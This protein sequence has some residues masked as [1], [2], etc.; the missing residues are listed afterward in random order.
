MGTIQEPKYYRLEKCDMC[1]EDFK[2][3]LSVMQR[4]FC[5]SCMEKHLNEHERLVKEYAALKIKIMHETAIRKLEKSHGGFC[6]R[7]L[8]DSIKAVEEMESISPDSFLSADE[9]ITAI[10]LYDQGFFFKINHKILAYKVDFFLP[11][12][13]IVLEVDGY[14]HDLKGHRTK[15]GKRDVDI[16]KELGYEWE[17][18]RIPT[19][20]IEKEPMKV[21]DAMLEI[22]NK[23]RELR[24][25]YNGML[26]E[27][28]S[29]ST[30]A[31]YSKLSGYEKDLLYVNRLQG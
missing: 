1:G 28:Y 27:N 21:C 18:V 2:S 15:D 29:K 13:K 31:Y 19:K 6:M 16:R 20:Y 9:I 26:P 12:E 7:D 14:A 11:D 23:Q 30:K 8:Y 25:K 24:K 10:L 22:A 4:Q 5:P 17:I 3:T